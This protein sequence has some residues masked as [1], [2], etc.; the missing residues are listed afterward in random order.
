MGSGGQVELKARSPCDSG[1]IA[2]SVR[3][4]T[5]GV[6]IKVNTQANFER[7]A[8]GSCSNAPRTSPLPSPHLGMLGCSLKP[9]QDSKTT[10]LGDMHVPRLREPHSNLLC[11]YRR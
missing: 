2:R 3:P 4:L 9:K 6:C 7:V 8:P 5:A 11:A 1:S 10:W